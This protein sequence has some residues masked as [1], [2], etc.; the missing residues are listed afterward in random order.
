V[1]ALSDLIGVLLPGG[2]A[3]GLVTLFQAVKSWREGK[4]SREE[5]AIK[6]W[7]QL[8]VEADKKCK[9]AENDE[10]HANDL[11]EYWRKCYADLEFEVRRTGET[12]IPLRPPLPEK[13]TLRGQPHA[14]ARRSRTR[15]A[16]DDGE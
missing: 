5:T 9:V 16:Q 4:S 3:I 1:S 13:K 8:A 11:A 14:P 12:A 7:Q 10:A 2:L 6:R 15:Q